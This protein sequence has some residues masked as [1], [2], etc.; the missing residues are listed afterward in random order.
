MLNILNKF[1]FFNKK[2]KNKKTGTAID[3][4]PDEIGSRIAIIDGILHISDE[5][6]GNVN[7][8]DFVA[9][10]KRSG[11]V[12]HEWHKANEFNDLF[13]RE[14]INFDKNTNKSELQKEV[15]TILT[16]AHEAKASDIHIKDLGTHCLVR[17]RIIGML[18][19]YITYP[20]EHGRS[21]IACIYSSMCQ[22]TSRSVYSPRE[23]HEARIVDQTY[24]P[25]GVYSIRVHTEPTERANAP[26]GV[27]ACMYLR[28]L[29]DATKASG[30]L[31]TRLSMLGFL[32]EQIDVFSFLTTRTGLVLISG[33]TGHGKSTVLKHCQE[34]MVDN[35]PQKSYMSVEDP[36]EY[37]IEGVD[38]VAV[39]TNDENKGIAYTNAIAGAMRSDP[40][41]LMIG[42]MRYA[43]AIQAGLQAAMTGHGVWATLHASNAFGIIPRMVT[44]LTET[45]Y[46][47]ALEYICE[48]SVLAGLEYQRLI[49]ILCPKCSQLFTE[50]K[51]YDKSMQNKIMSIFTDIDAIRVRGDD[52]C[53][54]C[55][56]RGVIGQKVAAE[57]IATD[58]TMLNFMRNGDFESA[59]DYWIKDKKGITHVQHA[60]RLVKEGLA[61]PII[62]E[63]RLGLPLDIE[64]VFKC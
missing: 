50:K 43:E 17:F 31:N 41:N 6:K 37:I 29:Y 57:V 20:A 24:L 30:D 60:L 18:S 25:K 10:Q 54:H 58:S 11:V 3:D 14:T 8:L 61:D 42:E 28:L 47:N 4:L 7:M 48:P 5:L 40:D 39:T 45:G 9:E 33:P 12:Q 26:E 19:N 56:F 36:P 55:N 44:L 32:P 59:K 52:G 64:G 63:D 62:T 16:K 22:A 46:S 53:E 23:R 51:D 21:L 49:P 35:R 13:N 15:K 34:A 2:P 38:Q 27:G 1:G